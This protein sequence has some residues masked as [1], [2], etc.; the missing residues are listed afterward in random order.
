MQESDVKKALDAACGASK[1][2]AEALEQLYRFHRATEDIGLAKEAG[3]KW[4]R[5]LQVH[6]WHEDEGSTADVARCCESLC[7]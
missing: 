3:F 6:G 1:V 2:P 4:L 5:A 7:R